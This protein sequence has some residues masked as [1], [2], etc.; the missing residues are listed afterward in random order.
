MK[1]MNCFSRN[2]RL[3]FISAAAFIFILANIIGLFGLSGWRIDFTA[4]RLYTLSDGSIKIASEL[5]EPIT[6]RFF[7]SNKA[8]TGYAPVKAFAE[9][10][11]AML[12]TYVRHSNGKIKLIETDPLPFSEAEDEA[13]AYGL[14]GVPI[15]D[16]G[17]KLYAGLVVEN[18]R[19]QSVA[20]PFL[21]F[22]REAFLEYDISRMLSELSTTSKP[23][24]GV[25]STL[26]VMDT[27]LPMGLQLGGG[28]SWA[29][30][31]QLQQLFEV[32]AV[33]ISA[34]EIPEKINLL[35]VI[36]PSGLSR[37][38]AYALD[39]FVLRGGRAVFFVD[40][41]SEFASPAT[42]N[43][44]ADYSAVLPLFEKW[45]VG[46]D[47][48]EVVGDR[49]AALQKQ[50]DGD[51]ATAPFSNVTWLGLNEENFARDEVAVG[52]LHNLRFITSGF[53]SKNTD[54]NFDFVPLIS[55][56]SD[57]M[58][59]ENSRLG[60]MVNVKSLLQNFTAT[61]EK[62]TLA[63]R[64]SGRFSSAFAK[65]PVTLKTPHLSEATEN[66]HVVII[67]DS[68]LLQ[69]RFWTRA[70]DVMGY[71]LLVPTADNSAFVLNVL[72][73]LSGSS[74]LIGLR[75][76]GSAL[77][78]F[79]YVDSLRK[80]AEMRFLDKEQQLQARLSETEKALQELQGGAVSQANT[81]L[82]PEQ[83]EMIENFK[84]EMLRTRKELR[85]VQ[86]ALRQDIESLGFW[87]KAVNMLLPPL[88]L[89]VGAIWHFRRRR[90]KRDLANS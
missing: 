71:R 59:I 82:S 30:I 34:T 88:I 37:E 80:D 89:C 56:S 5:K 24:I 36:H 17:S 3:S 78:P 22:D 74:S 62:Y 55:S 46:F 16:Q 85:D 49:Q 6:I 83:M 61:G 21:S 12:K 69:D 8:A 87:V 86:A 2:P 48:E 60:Q 72:D 28:G 13:V 45:G 19:D 64:I 33:S 7:F 10:I 18:I 39:Q 63:A 51:E 68:D 31:E 81:P 52:E 53:I 9:R 32:K 14:K 73:Q 79:T 84:H 44:K 4:D 65:A 23:V 41:A 75:G 15:D 26:P 1:L 40:P 38:T 67:A 29:V 42:L 20:L 25:L 54:S 47:P 66:A 27:Q 76:R 57:A 35:L 70:Q 58:K 90:A 11:R 50:A 43:S 77:R